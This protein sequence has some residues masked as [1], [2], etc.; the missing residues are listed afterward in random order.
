MLEASAGNNSLYFGLLVHEWSVQPPDVA[1]SGKRSGGACK[2]RPAVFVGG[3]SFPL[4]L[5]SP[6]GR[7]NW[8]LASFLL[9]GAF[10]AG[11]GAEKRIGLV[12]EAFVN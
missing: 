9:S 12:A 3:G 6:L 8:H 4:T 10:Q 11:R 7:G 1:G 2:S 5:P